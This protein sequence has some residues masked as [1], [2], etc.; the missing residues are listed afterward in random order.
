MVCRVRSL[1]VDMVGVVG[2]VFGGWCVWLVLL[3]WRVWGVR[4]WRARSDS[5]EWGVGLGCRAVGDFGSVGQKNFTTSW[6]LLK[7][8]ISEGSEFCFKIYIEREICVKEGAGWVG[9]MRVGG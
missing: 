1:V 5:G 7:L 3:V 8:R 4:V 2:V 9:R 6:L